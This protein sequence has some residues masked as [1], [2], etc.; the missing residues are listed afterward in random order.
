MADAQM[1]GSKGN[2]TTHNQEFGA[3]REFKIGIGLISGV[4]QV[5][6]DLASKDFGDSAFNSNGFR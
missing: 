3:P 2:T 5:A 1:V 4:S 6:I